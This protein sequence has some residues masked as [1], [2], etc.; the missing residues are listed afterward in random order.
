MPMLNN[1]GRIYPKD[2]LQ[3]A[4]N[5]FGNELAKKLRKSKLLK[6][7]EKIEKE[8]ENSEKESP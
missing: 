4:I 5:E 8:S 7:T 1:N 6:L 3:K 2:L